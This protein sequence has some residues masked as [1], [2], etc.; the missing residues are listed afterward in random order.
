M[1]IISLSPGSK[2]RRELAK[3]IAKEIALKENVVEEPTKQILSSFNS[4]SKITYNEQFA[5]IVADKR[6]K[7]SE[8]DD[9]SIRMR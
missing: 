7:E 5:Q 8:E 6:A 1:A 2:E 3:K 9:N 4:P